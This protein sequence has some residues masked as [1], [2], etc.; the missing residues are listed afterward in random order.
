MIVRN[1][2][3]HLTLS[4]E[5]KFPYQEDWMVWRISALYSS[6]VSS[7]FQLDESFLFLLLMV[8]SIFA[9][10]THNWHFFRSICS[11]NLCTV[12]N[13]INVTFALGQWLADAHANLCVVRKVSSS[14]RPVRVVNSSNID[15]SLF[16]SKPFNDKGLKCCMERHIFGPRIHFKA[17]VT[18]SHNSINENHATLLSIQITGVEPMWLQLER[19]TSLLGSRY[20]SSFHY[21]EKMLTIPVI[22]EYPVE[23]LV[24]RWGSLLGRNIWIIQLSEG[25]GKLFD[26][27]SIEKS[28]LFF[29]IPPVSRTVVSLSY[30]CLKLQHRE[31]SDRCQRI[32]G[33]DFI[34][35]TAS[36]AEPSEKY[37]PL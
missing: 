21:M 22:I 2:R 31:S 24:E 17:Y 25:V 36:A 1:V 8:L 14:N 35:S 3:S 4:W 32:L 9:Y 26:L 12:S 28:I 33:L 16:Q 37:W 18:N 20:S 5:A 15:S 29:L 10:W 6:P 13:P 19:L 23:G 7:L 11:P 30:V 34:L 27:M